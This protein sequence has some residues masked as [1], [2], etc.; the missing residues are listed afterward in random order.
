MSNVQSGQLSNQGDGEKPVD[1]TDLEPEYFDCSV[2]EESTEDLGLSRSLAA[3]PKS[4][5]GGFAQILQEVSEENSVQS[6]SVQSPSERVRDYD[7]GAGAGRVIG[8]SNQTWGGIKTVFEDDD[9]QTTSVETFRE[10]D[11]KYVPKRQ[12]VIDRNKLIISDA[13]A[14]PGSRPGEASRKLSNVSFAPPNAED[15]GTQVEHATIEGPELH[16]AGGPDPDLEEEILTTEVPPSPVIAAPEE[17][18]VT[19]AAEAAVAAVEDSTA[20]K[21]GM[22]DSSEVALEGA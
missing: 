4:R 9:P 8:D 11:P 12:I 13:S 10:F 7:W 3:T 18:P 1:K 2:L 14:A 15:G 6:P 17:S 19:L 21:D 20:K 5:E 16:P 22:P